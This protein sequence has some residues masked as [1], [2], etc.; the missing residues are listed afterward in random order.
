[1]FCNLE[2]F[3]SSE[4]LFAFVT[5]SEKTH[6][7]RLWMQTKGEGE[8]RRQRFRFEKQRKMHV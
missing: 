3:S 4:H 1:M 6:L 2:C 7:K 8:E 5:R